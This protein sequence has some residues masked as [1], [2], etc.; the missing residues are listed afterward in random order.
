MLLNCG[1]MGLTIVDLLVDLGDVFQHLNNE[2]DTKRYPSRAVAT[3]FRDY[4]RLC[5][6]LVRRGTLAL[7]GTR[8][9][10]QLVD[11]ELESCLHFHEDRTDKV[12]WRKVDFKDFL[13]GIH[14]IRA[15]HIVYHQ[16]ALNWSESDNARH[17][18]QIHRHLAQ[19]RA[20]FAV[21]ANAISN[22]AMDSL[23][24]KL[25]AD[26]KKVSAQANVLVDGYVKQHEMAFEPYYCFPLL[27]PGLAV[28]DQ[29]CWDEVS[30]YRDQNDAWEKLIHITGN[31]EQKRL[32][33]ATI[34]K[35]KGLVFSQDHQACLDFLNNAIAEKSL[36]SDDCKMIKSLF[37]HVPVSTGALERANN[38]LKHELTG[39]QRS[40]SLTRTM[41]QKINLRSYRNVL[42]SIARACQ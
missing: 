11:S 15:L 14:L 23:E 4:G 8:R 30:R 5:C 1:V 27:L 24:C 7:K 21:L 16:N 38:V 39:C 34:K 19:D 37:G 25:R 31:Q 13:I 17:A 9:L 35:M 10:S 26:R 40:T 22:V 3:R 20:D 42:L 29:R 2:M 32:V 12:P 33:K 18:M 6:D 28:N 41:K 36:S